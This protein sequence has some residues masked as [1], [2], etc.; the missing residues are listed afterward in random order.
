MGID[1]ASVLAFVSPEDF[2]A[3]ASELGVSVGK[4]SLKALIPILPTFSEKRE[5][6]GQKRGIFLESAQ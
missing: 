1:D 4:I 3:I 2:E 5:N 6:G